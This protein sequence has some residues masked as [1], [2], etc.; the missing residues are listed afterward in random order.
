M[1][2]PHTPKSVISSLRLPQ[3]RSYT[4]NCS[5]EILGSIKKILVRY[6]CLLCQVF[7]TYFY[8]LLLLGKQETS[9]RSFYDSF[10]IEVG[11]NLSAFIKSYLLFL[12]VSVYIFKRRKKHK[13]ITT[14]SLINYSILVNQPGIWRNYNVTFT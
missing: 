3:I 13:L 14:G 6:K 1:L 5:F 8:F 2:H 4:F 12:I 7:S 9:S 11:D 10:K